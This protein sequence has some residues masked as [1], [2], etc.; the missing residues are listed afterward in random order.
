MR[1]TSV[2]QNTVLPETKSERSFC[3]ANKFPGSFP[4]PTCLIYFVQ[5]HL[6]LS[7][8]LFVSYS[9]TVQLSLLCTLRA[10]R[11]L[12]ID[13]S[14]CT[15][16]KALRCDNKPMSIHLPLI[17]ALPP[18]LRIITR[19]SLSLPVASLALVAAPPSSCRVFRDFPRFSPRLSFH[20]AGARRRLSLVRR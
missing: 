6:F 5:F 8:V 13:F 11:Y 14:T 2:K 17:F 12:K 4:P 7:P 1:F 10:S 16:V 3:P 18:R 19:H 9:R 20:E 15:Q